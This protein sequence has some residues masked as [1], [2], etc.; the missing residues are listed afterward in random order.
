MIRH[1]VV[2]RLKHPKGSEAEKS[3]LKA[4][5][6]LKSIRTVQNFEMHRETSPKNNYSYG[7]S[8]DFED[9][10]AYTFYNDHPDH[11]A[12]VINRWLPEVEEFLEIDTVKMDTP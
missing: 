2:F 5:A 10:A 3:F 7:L 8:M 4:A 12:F 11:V 6:A 9:Q 1:S